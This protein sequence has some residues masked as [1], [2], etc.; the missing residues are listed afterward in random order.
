MYMY[1]RVCAGT[2]IYIYADIYIY[3]SHAVSG[4]KT[5]VEVY[6]DMIDVVPRGNKL[7]SVRTK[8]G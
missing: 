6:A 1:V 4:F 8:T 7:A 5:T 3:L 2:Y